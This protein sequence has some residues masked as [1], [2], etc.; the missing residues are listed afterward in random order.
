M[1]KFI[2]LAK[3]IWIYGAATG[4]ILA[5]SSTMAYALNNNIP[6]NV[7]ITSSK[8]VAATPLIGVM[9]VSELSDGSA[10]AVRLSGENKSSGSLSILPEWLRRKL[11]LSPGNS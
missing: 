7:S 3:K 1:S 11:G 8:V 10:C 5:S 6:E 9:V 4:I 2:P